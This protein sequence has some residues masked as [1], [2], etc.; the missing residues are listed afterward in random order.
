V[1]VERGPLSLVSI[2]EELLEWKSN[3]SESRKPRLT[4]VGSFVLT[5]Q[6]I[7]FAKVGTNYADKRRSIGRFRTKAAEFKM[8]VGNGLAPKLTN[9]PTIHL[10]K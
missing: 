6:H 7:L 8:R 3:G 1:G 2:T 5:T 9:Q 10:A 4:A